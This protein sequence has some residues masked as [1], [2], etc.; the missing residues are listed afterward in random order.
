MVAR[1]NDNKYPKSREAS[2][3]SRSGDFN[4][5]NDKYNP[6]SRIVSGDSPPLCVLKPT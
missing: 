5:L 4:S 2:R 1:C 3:G 6:K